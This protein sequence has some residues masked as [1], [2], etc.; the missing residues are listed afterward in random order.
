M[1]CRKDPRHVSSV[2]SP[3]IT[4]RFLG[5]LPLLPR[6]RQRPSKLITCRVREQS[7]GAIAYDDSRAREEKEGGHAKQWRSFPGPPTARTN[8]DGVWPTSSCRTCVWQ[9]SCEDVIVILILR[10]MSVLRVQHGLGTGGGK[11][12]TSKRGRWRGTLLGGETRQLM[13]A[14]RAGVSMGA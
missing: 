13:M 14:R 2:Y 7:S 5:L 8:V 12:S 9:P 10:D 1:L 3:E 4:D 6:I 11:A